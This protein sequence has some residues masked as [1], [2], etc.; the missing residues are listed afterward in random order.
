MTR[1][2]KYRAA[3]PNGVA[4]L[5]R[6]FA[7]NLDLIT[8]WIHRDRPSD[9]SGRCPA[10]TSTN[11]ANLPA[12]PELIHRVSMWANGICSSETATYIVLQGSTEFAWITR[13]KCQCR[14]CS[15]ERGTVL[16]A[17][18]RIKLVLVKL[19]REDGCRM[20]SHLLARRSAGRIS[21]RAS[22]KSMSSF[23]TS[24]SSSVAVTGEESCPVHMI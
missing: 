19:M 9:G 8:G 16:S 24:T 4:P 23:R 15:L 18:N 6:S 2:A 14:S 20:G 13:V 21:G 17:S 1:R 7:V 3:K 10:W 11:S 5:F 12:V 22:A